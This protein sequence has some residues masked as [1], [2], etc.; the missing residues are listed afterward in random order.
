M[1]KHVALPDPPEPVV[2]HHPDALAIVARMCHDLERTELEKVPPGL[3][4]EKRPRYVEEQRD[5]RVAYEVGRVRV[6]T[7]PTHA[8]RED[9]LAPHRQR[10][11][12]Q[13]QKN[14]GNEIFEDSR[15]RHLARKCK[16]ALHGSQVE[17]VDRNKACA[18]SCDALC[19][20]VAGSA[21]S[22]RPGHV[23]LEQLEQLRARSFR[24]LPTATRHDEARAGVLEAPFVIVVGITRPR[25]NCGKGGARR[26]GWFGPSCRG[27]GDRFRSLRR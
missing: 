21:S 12:R 25:R 17:H 14:R 3:L 11:A 5:A 4:G 26:P 19:A 22:H 24:P 6:P 18:K 10:S 2:A 27:D 23:M 9:T 15:A 7:H 1:A 16:G 13:K 8:H 20:V